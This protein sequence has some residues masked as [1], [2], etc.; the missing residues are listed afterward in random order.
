MIEELDGSAE[1]EGE[2]LDWAISEEDG[3]GAIEEEAPEVGALQLARSKAKDKGKKRFIGKEIIAHGRELS[4][5]F[6]SCSFVGTDEQQSRN[7]IDME[8]QNQKMGGD[9]RR[10][11]PQF[12][13]FSVSPLKASS[14][15]N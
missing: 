5:G 14:R 13:F 9:L 12:P 7:G 10:F 8:T 1:D 6:L 4:Y 3:A 2:R 11:S 15:D